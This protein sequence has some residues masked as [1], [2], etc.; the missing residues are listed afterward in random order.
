MVAP[1]FDTASKISFEWYKLARRALSKTDHKITVLEK[2]KATRENF[3][4][5][6]K[7]A[8]IFAFWDHGNV[9]ILASQKGRDPSLVDKEND[10]L[11]KDKEVWTMACLAG[12]ELG[13]DII[14]KGGNSFQGYKMSFVFINAPIVKNIFGVCA[15]EGFL[16]RM[17][18]KS[19]VES[20]LNQRNKFK[21]LIISS[22][23]IP[24][25]GL[26][27]AILLAYDLLGLV[28]YTKDGYE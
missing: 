23:L 7:N 18:G 20:E 3:E 24:G 26:Q 4:K 1:S 10:H 17:N 11:L 6:I 19:I 8:D 5:E 12:K 28:Y 13:K 25:Y 9:D 2:E 14:D 27:I 22:L 21:K 15:N 16:N